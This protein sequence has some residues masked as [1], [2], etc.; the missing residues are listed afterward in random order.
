MELTWGRRNGVCQESTCVP[1]VPPNLV[2]L[3]VHLASI[4]RAISFIARIANN[5]NDPFSQ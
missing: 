2:E 1:Y 3:L 4:L 5:T